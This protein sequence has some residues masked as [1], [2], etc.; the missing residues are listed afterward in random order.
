VAR[1]SKTDHVR[2]ICG[3]A[4]WKECAHPWYVD[5]R[6][7]YDVDAAGRRRRRGL[8]CKLAPLVGREP[9]DFADARAEAR[10]AI[11]AWKDG[12]DA[13]QPVP[14]DALSVVALIDEY[15]QRP[16]G[17]GGSFSARAA[18]V[19][20]NGRPFG[21]WLAAD[22]TREALEGFRRQRPTVAG[23]RDLALLRA[24][25]NWAVLGGLVASTPFKVST[26]SAVKL[27]R[28]EP[29]SRRLHAGEDE[30][31]LLTAKGNLRDLIVAALESACRL[32]E[33][34]SLQWHQVRGDLFLPGGKTKAKKPRRVPISSVLAG[35]L[36]TR[37]N[38]PAGEPLP[39]D[40]F[41]FGDQVG[42]RQ[43]SVD[44]AWEVAVLK[45]HG[46][47][48]TWIRKGKSRSA[49]LSA[50]S[51]AALKAIDLHFHDLRREAGSRWLDAGVPLSMI[52]K[53]LGHATLA[54]TSTYLAATAGGD[55]DAMRAFEMRAGR[56]SDPLTDGQVSPAG[57]LTNVD[58][59]SGSDHPEPT[60]TDATSSENSQQNA[61][62]H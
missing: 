38:D 16:G 28:E 30:A 54:Q 62:V 15:G 33:L 27:Q 44:R 43:G 1:Q 21:E 46:S 34:L 37:R 40:A 18:R 2:K 39:P 49:K 5:Y 17:A 61:I 3:C 7:G 25:F 10:R 20:V 12:R 36:A 4:K 42:R 11:V 52:Q 47:T 26:V 50:E 41:V 19:K 53:W 59:S 9:A 57:R 58:Q 55:A 51:R 56:L 35:V 45:A 13:R 29:R 23:N 32:G 14:G 24:A 48:P 6:E 31:L 8:R 60:S 22:V